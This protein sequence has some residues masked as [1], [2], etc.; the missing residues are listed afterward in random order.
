MPIKASTKTTG[1]TSS[2]LFVVDLTKNIYM[3]PLEYPLEKRSGLLEKF[4]IY[5]AIT[6]RQIY[7]TLG[8][9]AYVNSPWRRRCRPSWEWPVNNP[10]WWGARISWA[11]A[12]RIVGSW[13]PLVEYH[14]VLQAGPSAKTNKLLLSE[15]RSI[16]LSNNSSDDCFFCPEQST[17]LLSCNLRLAI[18][19]KRGWSLVKI[20][21]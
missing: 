7:K 10:E 21:V 3:S 15:L 17:K 16:H 13:T 2:F 11:A 19:L 14:S 9:K 12:P 1:K 4:V 8:R 6:P 5:P 20:L 18:H